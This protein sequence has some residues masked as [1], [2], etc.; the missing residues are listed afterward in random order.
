MVTERVLVTSGGK[1]KKEKKQGRG[2]GGSHYTAI[3][4]VSITIKWNQKRRGKKLWR[5]KGFLLP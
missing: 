4:K 5:S 3:I 2:R 1:M